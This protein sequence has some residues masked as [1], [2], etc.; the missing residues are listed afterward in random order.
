MADPITVKFAGQQ[1]VED[2]NNRLVTDKQIENWDNKGIIEL[3]PYNITNYLLDPS[4]YCEIDIGTYKK[5]GRGGIFNN[6][7]PGEYILKL[8]WEPFFVKDKNAIPTNIIARAPSQDAEAHG[9]MFVKRDWTAFFAHS[10]AMF[11][12]NTEEFADD[13]KILTAYKLIDTIGDINYNNE[14]WFGFAVEDTEAVSYI[15]YI[16]I[17]VTKYQNYIDPLQNIEYKFEADA[18][19]SD[20]YREH[21]HIVS[22]DTVDKNTYDKYIDW[23]YV[24]D[25]GFYCGIKHG[26]VESSQI[27]YHGIVT[28]G[29]GNVYE[30]NKITEKAKY[31]TQTVTDNTD[32]ITQYIRKGTATYTL[33][34][35]LKKIAFGDW[36]SIDYIKP[37]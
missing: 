4:V 22:Y 36:Y 29:W 18:Y 10:Y 19:L 27:L 16:K 21:L 11:I 28:V 33:A 13:A 30:S 9:S 12:D 17:S 6:L 24:I 15:N 1:I 5:I 14:S 37:E 20:D 3:T 25:P 32:S 23:N 35:T 31:I 34:G 8:G 26:P 2:T 7:K